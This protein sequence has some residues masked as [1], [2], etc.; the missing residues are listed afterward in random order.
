M[1][2]DTSAIVALLLEEDGH[3][4][5]KYQIAAAS[6]CRVGAPTLL[7]A[8]IVMTNLMGVR[9]RALLALLLQDLRVDVISFGPE[10]WSVAHE[11]FLR[12]GKGRHP[13][14]LNFGDCLTYATAS[15]AREPLLCVGNDFPQTDLE[16]VKLT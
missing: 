2:I 11:A 3:E 8:S 5:I 15:V 13:A 9:G 16:L 14:K 10:H 6:V 1:I 7:E 4:E 12:F